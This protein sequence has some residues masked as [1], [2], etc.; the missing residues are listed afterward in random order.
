MTPRFLACTEAGS[1]GRGKLGRRQAGPHHTQPLHRWPYLPSA[2]LIIAKHLS[3]QKMVE[4]PLKSKENVCYKAHG[5]DC[6]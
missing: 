3:S 5:L 1:K 2:K 4:N 6:F